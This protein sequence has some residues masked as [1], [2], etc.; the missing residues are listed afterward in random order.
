[1]L[2]TKLLRDSAGTPVG[3][4]DRHQAVLAT[5]LLGLPVAYTSLSVIGCL[6]QLG[7]TTFPSRVMQTVLRAFSAKRAGMRLCVHQGQ[8]MVACYPTCSCAVCMKTAVLAARHSGWGLDTGHVVRLHSFLRR[9]L[10][11][12]LPK[13]VGPGGMSAAGPLSCSALWRCRA[14]RWLPAAIA[15]STVHVQCPGPACSASWDAGVRA[16]QPEE[17][18]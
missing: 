12:A 7:Y 1:V 11:A 14:H 17:F 8:W 3:F 6:V 4:L 5:L 13:T 16:C 15:P 2:H 10:N 9:I 18:L